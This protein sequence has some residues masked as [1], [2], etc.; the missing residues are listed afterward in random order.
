[1]ANRESNISNTPDVK[2]RLGSITKQFT[3]MLIIPAGFCCG[4]SSAQILTG[5]SDFHLCFVHPVEALLVVA[6]FRP[7]ARSKSEAIFSLDGP[8]Y[9][10]GAKAFQV[11]VVGDFLWAIGTPL[12]VSNTHTHAQNSSEEYPAL[13]TSVAARCVTA[14]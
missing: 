7:T 3:S 9:Q 10:V 5:L 2:F 14:A 1:M 4:L 13:R 6:T 11:K 8:A 12:R